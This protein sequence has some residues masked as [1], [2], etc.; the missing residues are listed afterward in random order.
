MASPSRN[1]AC[2]CGSGK[3]YKHCCAATGAHAH[4]P[5]PLGALI[6]L[7][8]GQS[9]PIAQAMAHALQLHQAGRV[10]KAEAIYRQVV[11]RQPGHPDAQHLLGLTYHQTG[12]HDLAYTHITQ[13]ISLSPQAALFHNN[14]G[15]VCRAL[16]RLEEAQ[17]CYARALA[18][19]PGLVE[20]Q[21]NVG[22]T[23]HAQNK[24]DQ[25][26]THLR[27]LIARHPKYLSGYWALLT[28]LK[29][30][31]KQEEILQVCDVGLAHHPLDLSLLHAKGHTLRMMGQLDQS[32]QHYRQAIERQP[33][34]PELQRYLT[35]VLM[36]SG[37]TAGAIESLKNEIRLSPDDAS[38]QHLLA[39]LQN[40]N[41][42]RAPAAYVSELFNAYADN[43][44]QHL[45]GKLD[46]RTHSLVAQTL[47]DT[48]GEDALGLDVLDLGCGTGLF[49]EEI[50]DIKKTLAGIDLAS[51]MIDR[52]KERGIYDELIVGDLVDYLVEAKPGSFDL[53]VA[54]DV[55]VYIGDLLPVFREASR[56]LQPGRWFA[57]SLEAAAEA[58]QD[59]S[60]GPSGRYQHRQSYVERLCADFNFKIDRFTQTVIRKDHNQPIA[61]YIFL[62]QKSD[63]PV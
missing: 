56:I 34:V 19:Q 28:V 20:A 23:L 54:T 24:S 58:A 30:Q 21:R 39:S 2:P 46:Y 15:E 47:R 25:A 5:S 60:L 55:F 3:K 17:A 45:V 38:A 14:L 35:V 61:G 18:M 12:R 53:I 22:L 1:Q 36:Q 27:Q 32:A 33:Q 11:Q 41:T 37:D 59:F 31:S 9:L 50:K 7:E 44:D 13:A 57:F 62:L 63:A 42:D 26:E 52:C 16:N 40:T 43:F 51:R 4:S 6:R 8:T 10:R 48:L 29:E 49:G